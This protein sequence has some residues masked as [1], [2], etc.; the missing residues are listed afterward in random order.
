MIIWVSS[1]S[2]QV[3]FFTLIYSNPFL[4]TDFTIF[5]F[6]AT[7]KFDDCK[8]KRDTPTSCTVDYPPVYFVNIEVWVEAENALGKVTSDHINFDPVDKGIYKPKFENLLEYTV[9]YKLVLSSIYK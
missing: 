9:S 4:M 5:V 2:F 8:A 1:N 3:T 7:E 6:R